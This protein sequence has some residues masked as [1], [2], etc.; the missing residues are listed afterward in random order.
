MISA[1]NEQKK[2]LETVK[3]STDNLLIA[4]FAG[5]GKTTTLQMISREL[6][7]KKGLYLAYNKSILEEARRKFPKNITCKTTHGLAFEVYVRQYAR[8]L[9][10]KL[11]SSKIAEFLDIESVSKTEYKVNLFANNVNVAACAK[12]IVNNFCYSIDKEI[13][14]NHFPKYYIELLRNKYKKDITLEYDPRNYAEPETFLEHYANYCTVV[15]KKLWEAMINTN[16]EIG[17]THDAYLKL[18]QLSKRKIRNIDF[19]L[20]DESQDANPAVLDILDN[21][22]IQRIY[23]G[24]QYQQIYRWRGSLNAMKEIEG[25]KLFL[26]QSFRF[27][28]AVAE[29]GN[30]ILKRLGESNLIK[31]NP[32][33]NSRIGQ[34]DKTKIHTVICRT[35]ASILR[36]C[37]EYAKDKKKVNCVGNLNETLKDFESGY[38]LWKGKIDKVKSAKVLVYQRWENLVEEVTLTAEPDIKGIMNFIEDYEDET[39]DIIQR[40]GS[41]VINNEDNADVILTTAHKSKGMEW[42]QVKISNDFKPVKYCS[43]DELNLWYVSI[44]R[45]IDLLDLTEIKDTDINKENKL[46]TI[47]LVPRTVWFSNLRSILKESQWGKIKRKTFAKAGYRCEICGGCG[48]KWPV[49]CHEIWNYDD[50]KKIQILSGLIAL[51][52]SCHEVKHIGLATKNGRRDIAAQHLSKINN[53]RQKLTDSYINEQ[54]DKWKERSNYSWQLDISYL[55]DEFNIEIDLHE[56]KAKQDQSFS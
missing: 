16:N 45:A 26:T 12:R 4:A 47:E 55:K 28:G 34:I 6:S 27:G 10:Y 14:Y 24:D 30:R 20:I 19:I 31:P 9:S 42:S 3:N 32:I 44:T 15:A 11:T 50:E 7:H 39:L 49:E 56:R 13:G 25:S 29:A 18:Y 17:I 43:I 21:Q 51:C 33:I 8:K 46:L 40:I 53:W 37:L 23:V 54:F 41:T 36:R 22:D 52:P 35:N 48:L 2:I 38:Y 5:S 1:T